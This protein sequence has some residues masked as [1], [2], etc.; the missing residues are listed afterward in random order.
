MLIWYDIFFTYMKNTII[1]ND[2]ELVD[3]TSSHVESS[4]NREILNYGQE[5]AHR[6]FLPFSRRVTSQC[7][8]EVLVRRKKRFFSHRI[9]TIQRSTLKNNNCV[10]SIHVQSWAYMLYSSSAQNWLHSEQ[11]KKEVGKE[12]R[13]LSATQF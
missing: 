4:P 11:Q 7:N 2:S 8:A 10:P 6:K 3:S 9:L 1:I 12:S 5:F 13:T